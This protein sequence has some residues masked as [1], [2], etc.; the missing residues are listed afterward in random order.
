MCCRLAGRAEAYGWP[1]A[2]VLTFGF[3]LG[4]LAVLAVMVL[5]AFL[6]PGAGFL[7]ISVFVF[8]RSFSSLGVWTSTI[9]LHLDC[10]TQ[11]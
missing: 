10:D 8:I 11:A 3:L 5:Q 4:S 2:Q 6:N 7:L 9:F 1:S